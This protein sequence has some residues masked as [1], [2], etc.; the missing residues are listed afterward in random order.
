MGQ[1]TRTKTELHRLRAELVT[2][3]EWLRQTQAGSGTLSGLGL[4]YASPG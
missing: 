3:T 2:P 1:E 4:G